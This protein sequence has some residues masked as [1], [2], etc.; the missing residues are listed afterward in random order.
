MSTEVA[1]VVS[2]RD[3]AETLHR[4]IADHGGARVRARILDAREAAD[5]RYDVLVA[6]DLTS[7]LTPRL[8]AS[9]Q[10][11]GRRVLGL[12]DP[13]EPDGRARL[14]RLGVD[15]IAPTT[16]APEELL[17]L[18]DAL[19]VAVASDLDAELE[20][21]GPA[22]AG[23]ASPAVGPAGDGRGIVAVAG[24]SGGPGATEVALGLAL[25]EGRRG[26]DC[27]LVD[28][29]DV[30]PSLAQRLDLPLHPNVRTAVDV[31]EHRSGRLDEVLTGIEAPGVAVVCGLPDA[32]DAGEL[33]PGEV[34]D[35]LAELARR[36]DRVVVNAGHRIEEVAAGGPGV[37]RYALA[38]ELLAAA[39]AVVAVAAPTPVGLA[40]LLDWIADLRAVTDPPDAVVFNRAP[41]SRFKRGELAQELR[42]TY[43]P[44]VLA[45][46]PEDGRVADAAWSGR[47]VAAGPFTAAMDELARALPD[48]AAH[49]G[50][51]ARRPVS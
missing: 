30:A 3:W 39:G 34:C 2:A 5:E 8:V 49:D 20:R 38:R 15:E 21:L 27:A 13:T 24:P 31:V 48:P 35:V 51:A 12:H 43:A 29:D 36:H 7:F 10:R 45:F 18:V 23:A 50:F 4:F 9:L 37:G 28:A 19:G 6:E 44:P 14:R 40:R 42:R 1:I 26:R 46:A 32:A 11:D 25:A 22:P 16:A 33:H 47:P 17:E 41:R